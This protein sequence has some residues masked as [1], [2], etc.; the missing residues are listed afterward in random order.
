MSEEKRIFEG[1]LFAPGAQELRDIKMRAHN[2]DTDYNH[3]YEYVYNTQNMPTQV[4]IH[5]DSS[6]KEIYQIRYNQ[7]GII[8]QEDYESY[9]QAISGNRAISSYCREYTYDENGLI[10]RIY[11]DNYWYDEFDCCDLTLFEYDKFGNIIKEGHAASD[12]DYATYL[13]FFDYKLVYFAN[14]LPTTSLDYLYDFEYLTG[15][16][17]MMGVFSE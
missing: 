11:T 17:S 8:I 4:T 14:G 10:S 15:M 13:I 16:L 12:G 6:R 2:L 9:E 7:K 3:T 1:V 5:Y